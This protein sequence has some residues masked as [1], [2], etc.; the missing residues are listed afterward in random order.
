MPFNIGDIYQ[1]IL[2]QIKGAETRSV[3]FLFSPDKSPYLD[4][5][6]IYASLEKEWETIKPTLKDKDRKQGLADI[7]FPKKPYDL[8]VIKRLHDIF[9][10]PSLTHPSIFLDI[11]IARILTEI[12]GKHR[13]LLS[14]QLL[15]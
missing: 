4:I 13:N 8:K 7:I 15:L 9:L 12:S 1:V 10:S 2:S 11:C 5:A 6:S 3:D 14:P